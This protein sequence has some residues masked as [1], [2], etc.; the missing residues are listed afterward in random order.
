MHTKTN[1]FLGMSRTAASSSGLMRSV[2][3]SFLELYGDLCSLMEPYGAL[4]SFMEPYGALWSLMELLWS[5]MEPYGALW[6]LVEPY[7]ALWSPLALNGLC[8]T[9]PER[10]PYKAT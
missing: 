1:L 5:L 8:L 3:W 4:W 6:S 9:G 10:G 7:G 2:F